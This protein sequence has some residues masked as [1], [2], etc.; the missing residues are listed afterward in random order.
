MRKNQIFTLLMCLAVMATAWA[1]SI[2]ERQ[3][4]RIAADF[5]ASHSMP[6]TRLTKATQAPRIGAQAGSKNAAY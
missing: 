4:S 5:M 3:A 6:S 2:N 1:E